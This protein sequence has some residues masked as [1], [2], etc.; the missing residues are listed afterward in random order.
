MRLIVSGGGAK[1]LPTLGFLAARP[2]LY[3]RATSFAGVSGGALICAFLAKGKTPADVVRLYRKID[4]KRAVRIDPMAFMTTSSFLSPDYMRD[5]LSEQFAGDHLQDFPQLD[6]YALDVK[7]AC[8]VNLRER[9][10]QC[11]V[12]TALMASCAFPFVFPPVT[13]EGVL[14]TDAALAENC[15][16]KMYLHER[17]VIVVNQTASR[18][19]AGEISPFIASF[20]PAILRMAET[21]IVARASWVYYI[22]R[23]DDSMSGVLQLAVTPAEID[24]ALAKGSD[25]FLR[26]L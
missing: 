26:I 25:A 5:F 23:D 13:I 10:P 7:D 11:A 6:I 22:C 18:R 9:H 3:A 12:A 19:P 8:L 21:A 1:M 15:P 4:F 2:L 16:S 17:H 14:Y 24:R 20:A